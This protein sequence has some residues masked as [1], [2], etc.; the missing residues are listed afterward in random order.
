M[1]RGKETRLFAMPFVYKNDHFAKTGS[2]QTEGKHSKKDA[3]LQETMDRMGEDPEEN[4]EM[5]A[6]LAATLR[7]SG[8]RRG[9][10]KL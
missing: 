2:G 5:A 9:T 6:R 4:L 8:R 1:E 7:R 3:F 10:P